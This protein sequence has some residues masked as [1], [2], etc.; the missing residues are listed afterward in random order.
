MKFRV[1]DNRTP[2]RTYVR[3][4]E[5]DSAVFATRLYSL[6]R[7]YAADN[8]LIVILN[9]DLSAQIWPTFILRS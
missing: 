2:Y 3:G 6:F 8:P 1:R 7:L 9:F 5:E 4:R